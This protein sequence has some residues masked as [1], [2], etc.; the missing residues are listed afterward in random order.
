MACTS[1]AQE[2]A[3]PPA[4]RL[5]ASFALASI[6]ALTAG[7]AATTAPASDGHTVSPAAPAPA[8]VSVSDF[9]PLIDADLRGSLTY[10]N[11][12]DGRQ[13]AIPATLRVSKVSPDTLSVAVGY[14]DE[15]DQ[16]GA[17]TVSIGQDGT[18]FGNERVIERAATFDGLRLV[19]EYQGQDNGKPAVMRITHVI[20]TCAYSTSKIVYPLDGSEALERNRAAYT[21]AAE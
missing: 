2:R 5:V 3:Y 8:F 12:S 18:L 9:D 13:V 11:F 10:R 4:V 6:A 16:G 17:S 14:P 1:R 7:C 15:P 19:T 21:C 20:A